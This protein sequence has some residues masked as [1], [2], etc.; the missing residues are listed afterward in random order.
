MFCWIAMIITGAMAFVLGV[1]LMGLFLNSVRD[2]AMEDRVIR[3][4]RREDGTDGN[5]DPS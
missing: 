4:L 2:A 5:A 3:A 1:V